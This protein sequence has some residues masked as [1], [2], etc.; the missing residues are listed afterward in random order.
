[1]AQQYANLIGYSDVEPYEIIRWVSEKTIEVRE[2]RATRGEW[3]MDVRPG[4]FAYHVANQHEQVWTIESDES[5]PIIRAR[6][7]K[8]GRWH[9]KMGRHVLRDIPQKF[10]DYNF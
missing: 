10:Y 8:D 7:R 4:G 3:K 6:L 2:M 9:S 5:R 1:M